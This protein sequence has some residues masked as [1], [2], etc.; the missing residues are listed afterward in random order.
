MFRIALLSCLVLWSNCAPAADAGPKLGAG[1]TIRLQVG[2]TVK[3]GPGPMRGICALVLA[4]I[5]GG[6]PARK[7]AE[8]TAP[9]PPE[10]KLA[11]TE[12]LS[13]NTGTAIVGLWPNT[14]LGSSAS[15]ERDGSGYRR[16]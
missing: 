7:S 16:T 13:D 4:R 14:S 8:A 6:H 10:A 1:E 9:P 15:T 3:A 12:I 2:L 11:V 5:S